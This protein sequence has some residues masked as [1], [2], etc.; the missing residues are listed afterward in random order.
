MLRLVTTALFWGIPFLHLRFI[1]EDSP[2]PYLIIDYLHFMEVLAGI[3][4]QA[5][6]TE[7]WSAIL[8]VGVQIVFP[9]EI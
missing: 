8:E 4:F 2:L 3:Y 5:C 7:H 6:N 1:I 9:R